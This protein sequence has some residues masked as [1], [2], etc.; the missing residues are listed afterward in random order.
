M[1]IVIGGGIAAAGAIGSSVIGAQGANSAADTQANAAN[2]ATQAQLGMFNTVQQNLQ[3]YMGTGQ[4]ALL[5]LNNFLGLGTGTGY[6]GNATA[7]GVAGFQYDPAKDPEYQFMLS[8]GS[9]AIT[10]Q[11]SALGGVNSGAT[12]KALSDYGQQTALSSYQNEFSNWNTQMN[13]VF[14]RLMNAINV[15]QSSAAG[16]GTAATGTGQEIGNNLIGAGN[17]RAAGTM[18][19]A[20]ALSGGIQS[21]FN[22]P[23]FMN[24]ISGLSNGSGGGGPYAFSTGI[25]PDY[26]ASMN[27]PAGM[28]AV[29]YGG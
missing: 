17:A 28:S 15:G 25:Q 12:L 14:S 18:G 9:S 22:S 10:N 26:A 20:N 29:G 4:N 5:A 16:V 2:S 11:A 13:N 24:M 6:Y 21:F 7:P 23:G 19:S 3:P 27:L 1:A 8:Q